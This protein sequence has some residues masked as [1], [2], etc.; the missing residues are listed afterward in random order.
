ML[1]A[2]KV[3]VLTKYADF[4]NIFL[5]KSAEVLPECTKLI[6]HAI[7]L[8]ESK[9][10]F[11]GS[12]YSLS[13]IKLETLKTYI[14]TNLANNFIWLSKSAAYAL[15]FFVC[16][17]NDS[18]CLYVDY[19]GLYKLTIKNQYLLSWISEFLDRLE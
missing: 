16:K 19:Q 5:K 14:K 2:E 12:V 7:K 3:I 4:A 10:L 11:Y 8:E 1:L 13:P 17:L 9:Q 15:I 6:E 18:F